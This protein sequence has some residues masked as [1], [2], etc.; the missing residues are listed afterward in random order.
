MKG[1]GFRAKLKVL[2]AMIKCPLWLQLEL[3]VYFIDPA[4]YSAFSKLHQHSDRCLYKFCDSEH[5]DRLI[6]DK[7]YVRTT[8]ICSFCGERNKQLWE[9]P[10]CSTVLHLTCLVMSSDIVGE[11]MV[12]TSA[13]CTACNSEFLWPKILQGSYC[14]ND[15]SDPSSDV[16]IDGD[17]GV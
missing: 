7:N 17:E 13:A 14:E 5:L 10:R 11:T 8:F 12:P 15:V 6:T 3:C 2:D 16:S 1:K 4:G 9:C